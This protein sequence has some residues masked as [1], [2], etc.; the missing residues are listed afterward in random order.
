MIKKKYQRWKQNAK[1]QQALDTLGISSEYT[2]WY[3]MFKQRSAESVSEILQRW[4]DNFVP[5]FKT[6]NIVKDEN[7][8]YNIENKCYAECRVCFIPNCHNESIVVDISNYNV[9]DRNKRVY[10]SESDYSF[11]KE[12]DGDTRKVNNINLHLCHLHIPNTLEM[13]NPGMDIYDLFDI[14]AQFRK[15]WGDHKLY[16]S[17]L[18]KQMNHE[19]KLY[20]IEL[21]NEIY[22]DP[23]YG[24]TLKANEDSIQIARNNSSKYAQLIKLEKVEKKRLEAEIKKV[25]WE[26]GDYNKITFIKGVILGLRGKQPSV[27]V[28]HFQIEGPPDVIHELRTGKKEIHVSRKQLEQL[29]GTRP[30]KRD[31]GRNV[32]EGG[33]I[34]VAPAPSP[35]DFRPQ[36][37][38]GGQ[39]LLKAPKKLPTIPRPPKGPTTYRIP[40]L[41][42]YLSKKGKSKKKKELP[43][44]TNYFGAR[45]D[46]PTTFSDRSPEEEQREKEKIEREYVEAD[47]VQINEWLKSIGK[48]GDKRGK[49][50]AYQAVV[51]EYAEMG[52]TAN[53]SDLKWVLRASQKSSQTGEDLRNDIFR[54]IRDWAIE[55]KNKQ[56]VEIAERTGNQDIVNVY[57]KTEPEPEVGPDTFEEAEYVRGDFYLP[58]LDNDPRTFRKILKK[59]NQIYNGKIRGDLLKEFT[60]TDDIKEF[61]NVINDYYSENSIRALRTIRNT[62][63]AELS[64]VKQQLGRYKSTKKDFQNI[65]SST[66]R[67]NK[68]LK[69]NYYNR[70]V[71]HKYKEKK[72]TDTNDIHKE[73]ANRRITD[74]CL[75][76]LTGKKK[77]FGVRSKIEQGGKNLFKR[78]GGRENNYKDGLLMSAVLYS[79]AISENRQQ[80][81]E[82]VKAEINQEHARQ[83]TDEQLGQSIDNQ[84]VVPFYIHSNNPFKCTQKSVDVQL[85]VLGH[86]YLNEYQN[87]IESEGQKLIVSLG[88]LAVK[89]TFSYELIRILKRLKTINGTTDILFCNGHFT[90]SD[91]PRNYGYVQLTTSFS[92]YSI[93]DNYISKYVKRISI[94]FP[95]ETCLNKEDHNVTTL[96]HKCIPPPGLARC[97]IFLY[98]YKYNMETNCQDTL[99]LFIQSMMQW[100]TKLFLEGFSLNVLRP[101]T[102]WSLKQDGVYN[103]D[104]FLTTDIK[105][106]RGPMYPTRAEEVYDKYVG[107]VYNRF[108]STGEEDQL[109]FSK[110]TEQFSNAELFGRWFLGSSYSQRLTIYTLT[111]ILMRTNCYEY[112]TLEMMEL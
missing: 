50:D 105:E 45:E 36:K 25:N 94:T 79:I 56:K 71:E 73:M 70:V 28:S 9:V 64:T 7:L 83:Y 99:H 66:K 108:V 35:T 24:P 67:K 44:L 13:A 80:Y 96:L 87:D 3:N 63:Q 32:A 30:Q 11:D 76:Y 89:E 53:P 103:K 17:N 110:A 92:K 68:A 85:V 12:Y 75:L 34:N 6:Y 109:L 49:G 72:A 38:K 10:R 31:R 78:L 59:I 86:G 100:F 61:I 112:Q 37:K 46:A 90:I 98:F 8:K 107:G 23:H 95:S 18:I 27:P 15:A 81:L 4:Y 42:K 77:G 40:A 65:I 47:I 102:I 33:S 41:D 55:L 106:V 2:L 69:T 26:I 82:D 43:A 54:R 48:R 88:T 93:I 21:K 60:I 101:D 84:L 39:R 16:E 19:L 29:R 22:T 74:D 97:I 14:R 91:S 52:V 57:R 111:N 62:F 20:K 5:L 58:T 51:D 1:L 104:L